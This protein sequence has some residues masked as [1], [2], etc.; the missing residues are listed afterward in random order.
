MKTYIMKLHGGNL[1][2][3]SI[4]KVSGMIDIL[5]GMPNKPYPNRQ[6]PNGDC[7]LRFIA[8]DEQYDAIMKAIGKRYSGVIEYTVI[9]AK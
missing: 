6:H 7:E 5:T 3:Y 4:G 8:T 2:Q 1:T 9:F